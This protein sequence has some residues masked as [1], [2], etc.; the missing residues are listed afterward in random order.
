MISPYNFFTSFIYFFL[1]GFQTIKAM[2]LKH[3]NRNTHLYYTFKNADI[4]QV[5]E[6]KSLLLLGM[7]HIPLTDTESCLFC[8]SFEWPVFP[9][10]EST[11]FKISLWDNKLVRRHAMPSRRTTLTVLKETAKD[12]TRFKIKRVCLG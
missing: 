9:K 6:L 10:D 12:G 4:Y 5:K 3:S 7:K 8:H 2:C 11:A 1:Y